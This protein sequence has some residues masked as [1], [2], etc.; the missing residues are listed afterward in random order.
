MFTFGFAISTAAVVQ[1]LHCQFRSFPRR[2][3]EE[4]LLNP[5]QDSYLASAQP[6][7]FPQQ[8]ASDPDRTSSTAKGKCPVVRILSTIDRRTETDQLET[9]TFVHYFWVGQSIL[10]EV[11]IG[12]SGCVV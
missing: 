11:V 4:A 3:K 9:L 12:E 8:I 6:H 7:R 1:L 5:L 10:I 2:A